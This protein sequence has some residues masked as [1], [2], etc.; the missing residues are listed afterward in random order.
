MQF[1]LSFSLKQIRYMH[2]NISKRT[3][4]LQHCLYLHNYY[5]IN[6]LIGISKMNIFYFSSS[7]HYYFTK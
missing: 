2:N 4:F 1:K 6:Q 7:K 5:P 3:V